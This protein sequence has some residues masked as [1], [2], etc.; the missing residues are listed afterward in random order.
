M[1]HPVTHSVSHS[2]E[3]F[4]DSSLSLLIT[5]KEIDHMISI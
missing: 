3:S 1:T 2:S 4:S 5:D